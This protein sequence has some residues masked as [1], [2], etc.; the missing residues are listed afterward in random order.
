MRQVDY[1]SVDD[2]AMHMEELFGLI[3]VTEERLQV[4]LFLGALKPAIA[5]ELERDCRPQTF[6]EAAEK[7]K[8]IEKNYLRYNIDA[9]RILSTAVSEADD[10]SVRSSEWKSVSDTMKVI[11]DKLERIQVNLVEL[12]KRKTQF[13]NNNQY[14]NRNNNSNNAAKDRPYFNTEN[15]VCFTCG[16]KGHKSFQCPGGNLNNNSNPATGSNSVPL[17]SGKANE[18]Q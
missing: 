18:Q 8:V 17:N 3:G 7:A 14:Y 13:N 12:D 16:V 4:L 15:I 10:M 9:N 6:N 2:M 11:T 1:L 5:F